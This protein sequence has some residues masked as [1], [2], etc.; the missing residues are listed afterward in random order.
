LLGHVIALKAGSDYESLV[1]DRI[2]RPL[3]MDSTRITLTPEL[4]SRFATGHNRFGET[5]PSWERQ[6]QLG[7]SAL[8][9]TANDM[10]KFVS[11][12]LGVT[13][14]SLTPLMEKTHTLRLDQTLGEDLGLAWGV[15]RLPQEREII[16]H[17]G[18]APGY[19]TFAG[20]DK[21]RRRGVVILSSSWDLDVVTMGFLLL[22]SEW[23]PDKRPK[24]TRISSQIYDSSVGQYELSPSFS[25]GAFAWRVFL[26]HIPKA[27][28]YIPVGLSLAVLF[29]LLRR[30]A[31]VRKRW[32]IVGSSAL[33]TGL[34]MFLVILASSHVVCALCHPT[35]S[36]R[37][38]GDRL[39]V[40]TTCD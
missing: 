2:C 40:H 21:A 24:E 30:A 23:E 38:E 25:V 6:T 8:R 5:V 1:V 12:N 35:L 20:F 10:V 14:S 27:F 19:V 13:P 3:K 34:L 15:T 9:S 11:A 26:L 37:R 7:G 32:I 28:I 39:F 16:W 18:G 17:T 22:G 29:I 33:V 36:I 31:T 4:K